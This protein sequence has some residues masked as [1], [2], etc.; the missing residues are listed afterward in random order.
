MDRNTIIGILLIGTILIAYSI[1]N[2]PSQEEI[3]EARIKRDSLELFRQ[4]MEKEIQAKAE[5]EKL[6]LET[7]PVTEAITELQKTE[8]LKNLY[9]SF[10]EASVGENAFT[11]LENNLIKI[12]ISNK[13]GRPYRVELKE[14]QTYDS[15][16]LILFD[17][18][19]TI[20]G[21]D[22]FA[23]NRSISTN[24]LFFIPTT[25]KKNIQV[26]DK[27]KSLAL[28]LYAGRDKYIEYK[29]TLEP[30]SYLLDFHINISG[31]N[32]VIASNLNFLTLHW[33][34]YVHPQEKGKQNENYNTTLY[35]KYPDEV[36]YVNPRARSDISEENLRTKF[37]WMAFKQQFFS[38]VIIADDFF[39]NAHIRSEKLDEYDPYLKKFFAEISI[40][41]EGKIKENILL[42]FY[43]GPN[44]FN[45][46]KKYDLELEELVYM[47]RNIVRWINR[48][49]II[50]IFNFFNSF[51][52]NYG[53]IILLLTLIIK[54]ALF[55]LTYKSYLSQAKMRVLK[56][57][58]DELN[59]KIP[60]EKTM[61]RQ[62]ATMALYKKVGV[63]PMGGCLPMILQMPILFAM[64]RFFPTSIEL[65]QQS[66]LWA[67]DLST[68]DSILDLPFNIPMYGDHISLFTLLMTVSTIITMKIGN[69][70]SA[71]STQMPGMKGMMYI[72]P[73]M[74][75]LI[76]NNFS[77]GLT[78]YYFLANIITFGQN[79][80][81]KRFVDDKEILKKLQISKK[82]QPAKK[83]KFQARLEKMTR[84]RGYKLPKR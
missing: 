79:A 80:L 56:P 69:Q 48:F 54:V 44:H 13:G 42:N 59:K 77:S 18:D 16:P 61:E 63:S 45:T 19:S 11:T 53:L 75:M 72:M 52:S 14:Y 8:N 2:K 65:R 64:F 39:L 57:Q 81:F 24:N 40:P 3:E 28:R 15:L 43:F 68:Y 9:G 26:T 50:P 66:F 25:T 73:F 21:L 36:K 6:T 46:L 49:V 10:A 23:Q 33:E 5:A 41:Y 17:G 76:L 71:G 82:K 4:E 67:D 55:P 51:I 60:K 62:Q 38:S 84:E 70:F 34:I 58:I 83:S 78:Y 74:F 27:A 22:F 35:Y 1:I 12:K 30:N 32:D 47:G 7:V 37:K 20:F 29:Y 31:M